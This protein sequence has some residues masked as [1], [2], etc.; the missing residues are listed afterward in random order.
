MGRAISLG[1]LYHEMASDSLLRF[2]GIE[3]IDSHLFRD[4]LQEIQIDGLTIRFGLAI[5]PAGCV[6]D[7]GGATL[8]YSLPESDIPTG[9]IAELIHQDATVRQQQLNYPRPIRF[10]VGL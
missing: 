8:G 1:I 7:I 2:I 6:Q 9:Y 4:S 10:L 5:P 3:V